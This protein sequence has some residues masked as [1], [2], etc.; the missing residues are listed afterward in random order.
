MLVLLVAFFAWQPTRA[1]H[2]PVMR[3]RV[4]LVPHAHRHAG[5]GPRV[6]VDVVPVTL[7]V[8]GSFSGPTR[9][10]LDATVQ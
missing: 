7:A 4:W 8:T 10:N 1:T 9:R 3:A 6:L 5:I 2:P